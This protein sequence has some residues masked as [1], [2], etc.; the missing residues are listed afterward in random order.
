[1]MTEQEIFEKLRPLVR[2]VT[3]VPEE[4]IHMDSNFMEDLGA[5]SL[6]LLDLSFLIEEAS[7]SR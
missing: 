5:A 7:A 2:E 4:E 6:D 3:G 1:M